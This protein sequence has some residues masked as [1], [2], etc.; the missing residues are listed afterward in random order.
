MTGKKYDIGI[1]KSRYWRELGCLAFA[2]GLVFAACGS[3]TP[4]A[5]PATTA[6]TTAAQCTNLGTLVPGQISVATS[7]FM[8]IIGESNGK[9]TGLDGN[10]MA[11]VAKKLGCTVKIVQSDFA[12]DLAAVQSNRVDVAI[13]S[14]G[15][16]K[17]RE[18][19]G[20]FTDPTYYQTIEL[21]ETKGENITRISQMEGKTLCT[22]TGFVFIPALQKIPNATLKTYSTVPSMLADVGLGRCNVGFTNPL[23]VVYT[24]TH[25]PQLNL[26]YHA[27]TPTPAEIQA[28]PLVG[29]LMN[30]YEDAFYLPKS[31]TKLEAAMSEVIDGF[32]ASGQ[33][34]AFL[35]KWGVTNVK[36]WLTPTPSLINER[37][38][39]D[40]PAGWKAPACS[41]TTCT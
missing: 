41:G 35:K 16:T 5:S 40:R 4:G 28:I 26:T 12:G 34:A 29:T 32:Y 18:Q 15:W 36:Q 22:V 24:A 11:A 8:P 7:P 30:R 14:I 6:A 27:F 25:E 33:E 31:D 23:V 2:M 39:V 10:I 3:G 1:R 38:G 21:A 37:I 13:G 19:Q 20:L 9:L 17:I